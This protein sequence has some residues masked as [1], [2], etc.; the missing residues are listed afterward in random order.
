MKVTAISSSFYFSRK[1]FD[2]KVVEFGSDTDSFNVNYSENDDFLQ[3]VRLHIDVLQ[4]TT[5]V[6]E[7]VYRQSDGVFRSSNVFIDKKL[8]CTCGYFDDKTHQAFGAALKSKTFIMD[9]EWYFSEGEYEVGSRDSSDLMKLTQ[10]NF[11]LNK[12]G[13]NLT[14]QSC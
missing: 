4:E 13:Y 9:G 11:T 12:Q 1:H 14:N 2:T 10:A 8:K 6:K 7:R 3:K 5:P